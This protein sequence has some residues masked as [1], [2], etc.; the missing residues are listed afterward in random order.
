MGHALI[1]M[2]K[3]ALSEPDPDEPGALRK[4]DEHRCVY[5]DCK[6]Q[7]DGEN[8]LIDFQNEEFYAC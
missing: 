5:K 3:V 1:Y 7:S 6:F 2:S 4:V 8:P